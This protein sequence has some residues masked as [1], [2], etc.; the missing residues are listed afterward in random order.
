M[1]WLKK[2]EWLWW[3]TG[4]LLGLLNI[5]TFYVS[6]Y[7]L[8]VSTT[9]SRVAAMLVGLVAPEHVAA[10]AY[11]QKVKPIVDWQFMLV[12]GI[13]IGAFLA[14]RLSRPNVPFTG[15]LPE[16]WVNRFGTSQARRWMLGIVGGILVGFG[17]RLADG[18]TSG[19]ALS[20]GLQLAV[21][22]WIFLTAMMVSGTIMAFLIFRRV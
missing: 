11:W 17:A 15:Q 21:S 22:S 13:P 12:I 9:F 18:C 1:N 20:G 8:S 3:Q 16:M 10:N 7:Y 4:L 6:D 14:A 5:A 2:E 19:H